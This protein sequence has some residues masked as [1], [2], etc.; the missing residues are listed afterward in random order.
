MIILW[1]SLVCFFFFLMSPFSLSPSLPSPILSIFLQS[2]LLITALFCLL[3]F[4]DFSPDL[5]YF[6]PCVVLGLGCCISKTW[7]HPWTSNLIRHVPPTGLCVH[8]IL[9]TSIPPSPAPYFSNDDSFFSSVVF[10]THES[11]HVLKFLSLLVPSF[12]HCDHR[13]HKQWLQGFC[14]C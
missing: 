1:K 12:T 3:Y 5:E 11:V 4:I 7:V 13:E 9:V 10:K 14:L 2:Q 8:P 6:F